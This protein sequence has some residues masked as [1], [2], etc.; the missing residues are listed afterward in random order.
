MGSQA[1]SSIIFLRGA[2]RVPC[3]VSNAR[4]LGFPS[5][6][7][8]KWCLIS[9]N[10]P[11]RLPDCN[12]LPT[13]PQWKS[14]RYLIRSLDFFLKS[15]GRQHRNNTL[16]QVAMETSTVVQA[17]SGQNL[18]LGRRLGREEQWH[19]PRGPHCAHLGYG[20]RGRN[21]K[22]ECKGR[23]QNGVQGEVGKE[24]RNQESEEKEKW[25]G[26]IPFGRKGKLKGLRVDES[27]SEM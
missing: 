11:S 20:A 13:G 10:F 15:I 23:N 1:T 27:S 19:R 9:N 22:S 25:N 21:A 16:P 6:G 2:H 17:L 12:L 8:W 3:S 4:A 18:A 14:S 7:Q 24:Q 5:S 26:C